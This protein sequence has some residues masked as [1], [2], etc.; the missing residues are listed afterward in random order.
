MKPANDASPVSFPVSVTRLPQKGMPV[1]IEADARQRAALAA[2]HGLLAVERFVAELVVRPWKGEGVRVV[3]TVE[4][5]I[6]QACVVTLEPVANRVG[7]EVDAIFVPEGSR[8]ARPRQALE[9]EILLDPEGPDAP[10]P[11]SG[12]TIDAGALAEEFFGLGIDPYPRAPAA[13]SGPAQ[14]ATDG[15]EASP[16]AR[17]AALKPKS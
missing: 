13:T 12:D 3:G 4:A 15:G 1:R 8:L 9:G 17:L 10:E 6:L 11:F 2:A 16:F 5:A 14:L 7:E